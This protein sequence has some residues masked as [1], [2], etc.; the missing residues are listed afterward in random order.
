MTQ[1]SYVTKS[2]VIFSV[3]LCGNV[4][5]LF[6]NGGQ[7]SYVIERCVIFSVLLCGNVINL[8]LV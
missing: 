8:F 7:L 3:L 2:C 5:N 6:Y 1:L 4:I